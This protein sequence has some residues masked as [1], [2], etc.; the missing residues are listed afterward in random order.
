MPPSRR[1]II[2]FPAPGGPTSSALWPPAAAISSA[3]R[4][5]TGRG[6]RRNRVATAPAPRRA[7]LRSRHEP[8][9]SLTAC[10]ASQGRHPVQ[11]QARD[12]G[13]F[14]L[15]AERQQEST[16]TVAP[17]ARGHR[18]HAPSRSDR[19]VERQRADQQMSS[20][21]RRRG[22]AAAST[23]SAIG[24]SNV[25]AFLADVGRREVDGDSMRRK[26]E[27]GIANRAADAIAALADAGVGEAD[28]VEGR[29]SEGTSTST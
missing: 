16:I 7:A 1:A 21:S 22:P 9:G 23:P 10:T 12:D 3:R 28:H 17:G 2:V 4:A 25:R 14:G 29:Q 5:S 15:V 8:A 18:Q 24:R 19:A 27:A 26:L 13:R 11:P 6:R 20:T